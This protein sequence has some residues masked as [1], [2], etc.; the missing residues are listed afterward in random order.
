MA[1]ELIWDEPFKRIY[2]K[3]IKKNP[4]IKILFW[5][6]LELFVGK[7]E[8]LWAFSIDYYTRLIFEFI[9]EGKVALIDVGSH[10]EVY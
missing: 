4:D 3:K 7:L 5:K 1:I 8:G 6:K 9:D 10:D 2:K